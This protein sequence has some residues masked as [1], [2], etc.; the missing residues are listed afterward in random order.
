MIPQLLSGKRAELQAIQKQ[1]VTRAAE[2][3]ALIA[4]RERLQAE[5]A[6]LQAFLD[7][8]RAQP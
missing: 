7:W 3:E 4:D 2:R 5:I 1:L 6:E 8:K